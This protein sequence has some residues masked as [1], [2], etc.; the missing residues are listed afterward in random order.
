MLLTSNALLNVETGSKEFI[1]LSYAIVCFHPSVSL[2]NE[3]IIVK[4]VKM[5][6]T[7]KRKQI[8]YTLLLCGNKGFN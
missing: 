4:Y 2:N 3:K 5:K 6:P 8:R 1:I 7:S